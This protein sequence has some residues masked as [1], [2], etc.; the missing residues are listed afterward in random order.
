MYDIILSGLPIL[1]PFSKSG[2]LTQFRKVIFRT[3]EEQLPQLFHTDYA[4]AS[5]R[6]LIVNF[7]TKKWEL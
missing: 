4:T 3:P 1:Y 7:A 2:I 6:H 5:K